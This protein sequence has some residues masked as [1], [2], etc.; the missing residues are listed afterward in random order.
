MTEQQFEGTQLIIKQHDHAW[1]ARYQA[2]RAMWNKVAE[3]NEVLEYPLHVDMELNNDCNLK[4]ECCRQHFNPLE[5][6]QMPKI[7]EEKIFEEMEG[8]ITACKPNY[9]GEPLLHFE[10]LMQWIKKAKYH[11]NAIDIRMNTNGL[12]LTENRFVRMMLL[13]LD[14][15]IFSIDKY[16]DNRKVFADIQKYQDKKKEYGFERPLIRIS[17]IKQAKYEETDLFVHIAD[18]MHEAELL[19]YYDWEQQ[20][21]TK[22]PNWKCSQLWQRLLIKANGDIQACCGESHPAKVIGNIRDMTVHEAWHSELL[23]RYR[24]LHD[25]GAS[26][27]VEMCRHCALRKFEVSKQ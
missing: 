23:N 19:P 4:C 17:Y 15:L 27:E 21:N 16:H 2:Y 20:D 6:R 8:K 26:H 5:G 25:K 14:L 11:G 24:A 18:E 7:L 3:A 10:R 12:L 9:L 22:L 13:G 1:E